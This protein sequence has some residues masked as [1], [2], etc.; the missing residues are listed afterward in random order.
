MAQK[1]TRAI[2]YSELTALLTADQLRIG[3]PTPKSE[4]NVLVSQLVSQFAV[5]QQLAVPLVRCTQ[6]RHCFGLSENVIACP[7][8]HWLCFRSSIGVSSI[9]GNIGMSSR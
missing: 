6:C 8:S 7:N 5:G 1:N 4:Q 3:R 9:R 2:A